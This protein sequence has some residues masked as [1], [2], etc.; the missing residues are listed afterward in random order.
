M[1]FSECF[2]GD[3]HEL[4]RGKLNAELAEMMLS[5]PPPPWHGITHS[6]DGRGSKYL[7]ETYPENG[8]SNVITIDHFFLSVNTTD[9]APA[10]RRAEWKGRIMLSA[11]Y[12]QLAVEWTVVK[13]WLKLWAEFVLSEMISAIRSPFSPPTSYISRRDQNDDPPCPCNCKVSRI[14][15]IIPICNLVTVDVGISIRAAPTRQH[16]GFL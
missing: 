10:F 2:V 9:P 3:N 5:S 7:R 8:R 16:D 13:R 14:N 11:D 12:N 4:F 1:L 15:S 6:S